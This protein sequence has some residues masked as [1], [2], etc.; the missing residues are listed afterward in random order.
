MWLGAAFEE[1]PGAVLRTL[2][3]SPASPLHAGLLTPVRVAV[4]GNSQR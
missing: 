4:F 1:L 3:D 2:A